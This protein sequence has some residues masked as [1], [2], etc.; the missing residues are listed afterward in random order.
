MVVVCERALPLRTHGHQSPVSLSMGT[1]VQF[2]D[3][4]KAIE[5]CCWIRENC[6]VKTNSADIR[7]LAF[8]QDVSRLEDRLT[9]LQRV[10][11]RASTEIDDPD[12]YLRQ[13]TNNRLKVESVELVGDFKAT[14]TECRQLLQKHIK[15]D[16]K[17]ASI[18]DSA[19]WGLSTQAQVVELRNRIQFHTQKIYLIIEPVQ[20]GLIVD[21]A[22]NVNEIL[23]L[24][25]NHI[26][27][28]SEPLP[29]LPSFLECRFR[30]ALRRNS[31]TQNTDSDYI[32]LKEGFNA[33]YE[34]YRH[35][36][37]S[38]EL[39][40]QTVDQ[41]LSLLKAHW[42]VEAL[43][44][45]KSFRDTRPGS[46]YRRMIAQVEQRISRQYARQDIIRYSE[47]ELA[48]LNDA[49][50]AIW[51]EKKV[52]LLPPLTEP[53]G[54]EEKLI[55]LSLS[56]QPGYRKQDLIFFRVKDKILRLVLSNT[57]ENPSLPVEQL[58]KTINLDHD[59]LVPWYTISP[60]SPTR[61]IEITDGKGAGGKV[62]ELKDRT[63]AFHFQ[64]AFVGYEVA[65]YSDK[66]VC[67]FTVA[68]GKFSL[69]EHLD[70]FGETQLWQ[71]PMP[72]DGVNNNAT[73]PSASETTY[74]HSTSSETTHTAATMIATG[75]DP[76][77]VSVLQDQDRASVVAK[78]P[79][80][81]L[82][83]AFTKKGSSYTMW[84]LEI[85]GL[86]VVEERPDSKRTVIE[87]HGPRRKNFVVRKLSVDKCQLGKWDL[88][89]FA[90]PRH[91]H[92]NDKLII[93][94]VMCKYIALD[95][96]SVSERDRFNRHL[97]FAQH[98]WDKQVKNLEAATRAA[99]ILSYKPSIT[100]SSDSR[101]ASP[102]R[103]STFT[104]CSPTRSST[105]VSP[106]PTRSSTLVS[107][108]PPRLG[109]LSLTC[110]FEN[111]F[112]KESMT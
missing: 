32:P 58:E 67:N 109:S 53:K 112:A 94:K 110:V 46:L 6:F 111:P 19:F 14:L 97:K 40:A 24:L 27:L 74:L 71:W 10:F 7:Y 78:L 43:T 101:F 63:D 64:Q 83:V 52:V 98:L 18:L 8:K 79:P 69:P 5:I 44:R 16:G 38:S 91:P 41:Y 25:R 51:P 89:A 60:S 106:S 65:S 85:E 23:E 11:E 4:V 73:S 28:A 105:L 13:E 100:A 12:I 26:G 47:K 15:F 33:L 35:S 34:H 68:T 42:L 55:A 54:R 17:K 62:Y 80:P 96:N 2:G 22:G 30:N 72:P 39:D 82:L 77:I 99:K 81:P 21:I 37:P 107:S 90:L 75:L 84:N 9:Q 92:Y 86:K 93:K 36:M 59:G 1:P 70:G 3:V 66:V 61:R 95:F 57:F 104:P 103:A 76:T 88:A 45:S 20:L 56:E 108:S 50:F 49:A 48:G 29:P 31:P 87:W 102:S